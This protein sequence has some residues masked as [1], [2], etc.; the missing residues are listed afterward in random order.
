MKIFRWAIVA[1]LLTITGKAQ[2]SIDDY[3]MVLTPITVNQ[4]PGIH[5]YAFAQHNGEWLIIG[6]RLDG[7]HAR[8]PF[9][10]FAAAGNN[11]DIFVINPLSN[12]VWSA[13]VNTLTAPIK[14]QLQS[15]NMNF[16]QDGDT[17]YIIGGYGFSAT[18]NDH[19]THPRLTAI[20]VSG[21]MQ[22]IKQQATIAPYIKQATHPAFAVT[23]AHLGKIGNHY[24]LVG[25]HRFEGRYNPMNG[26]S[27]VQAYTNQIRKFSFQNTANQLNFSY[28][29]SITDPIHLHRRDYNL[30]PQIYPDGSFGYLISSGVFQVQADLP[31]LYPV[32]VT[33]S[34]YRPVQQF[35]Q[36]LSNYHSGKVAVYDAHHNEMHSLFFGGISQYYY[37]NG[38]LV[39][40]NQVPFVKTIS[41][42]TRKADS[43]YQE[44]VLPI[45]MP[46][47]RGA[48]S[49]FLINQQ[50][51]LLHGEV[52]NLN[53]ITADSILLGHVYGGILSPE[54][55]PFFANNTDVTSPDNGV[56]AIY[57]VKRPDI[58]VGE[59]DGQNPY[60]IQL[61]PN[62]VNG[63][64]FVFET[65]LRNTDPVYF[66]VTNAQ[67]KMVHDGR[68]TIETPGFEKFLVE[69]PQ[70][71]P[72]GV[73]NFTVVF[74]NKY[75][76]T[77]KVVKI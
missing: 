19:V 8:Q 16:H 3:T 67:G 63:D 73:Y 9:R 76:V 57:L 56:I 20:Q 29:D 49:E 27:F 10:S 45:E 47:L 72:A 44:V 28:L 43:T 6:G 75:Y 18:A 71:S 59:I 37:A 41:R 55:N 62:P 38:Q 33:A 12:Q 36:Y 64:S 24:Y 53:S 60:S 61:A 65:T 22:A 32:E 4:A 15:T 23:G 50:L 74:E 26:P 30:V 77:Q 13:S 69:L 1:L 46:S 54:R 48:S 2:N 52:V 70:G 25:G 17:L 31:F 68:Y 5:S 66:F 35:N 11:T 7:L 58:K 21:L 34:G 14:E 40:D 42:L 39:Q 51:P